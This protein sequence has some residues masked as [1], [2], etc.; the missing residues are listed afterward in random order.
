MR[1]QDRSRWGAA[2][3][4]AR[5]RWQGADAAGRRD[6]TTALDA[7]WDELHGAELGG[8]APAVGPKHTALGAW[9]AALPDAFR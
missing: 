7:L 2:L 6:I 3:A 1:A 9:K 5:K 8:S 4:A